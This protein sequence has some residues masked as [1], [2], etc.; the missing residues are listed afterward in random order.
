MRLLLG[1]IFTVIVLTA[2]YAAPDALRWHDP[3]LL[4]SVDEAASGL[5]N[6]R[7]FLRE[8]HRYKSKDLTPLYFI[9]RLIIER[10]GI[11]F[12]SSRTETQTTS[13]W[14]PSWG[15]TWVGGR[16]VPYSGGSTVTTQT[17]QRKEATIWFAYRDVQMLILMQWTKDN[18]DNPWPWCLHVILQAAAGDVAPEA[19]TFCA[20]RAD[21]AR[22]AFDA[23][24]TLITSASATSGNFQLKFIANA[25]ASHAEDFDAEFDTQRRF[26]KLGWPNTTGYL[27]GFVIPGSPAEAAGLKTD[28]IIFDVGGV[29]ITGKQDYK[30]RVTAATEA[31]KPYGT[32]DI[33]V[34]RE[35]QEIAV[36]LKNL[37]APY[38]GWERLRTSEPAASPAPP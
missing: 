24:F 28:D 21:L 22:K 32:L 31:G 25:G 29:P 11:G 10:D 7:P 2:A 16:Y 3:T 37:R 30:D 35:K 9:D 33:K 12:I 4:P 20:Q 27:V 6:S 19:V 5:T 17:P 13:Q 23:L 34:F 18:P 38:F 36:T 15:G 8:Q 26:K 14:V 1:L